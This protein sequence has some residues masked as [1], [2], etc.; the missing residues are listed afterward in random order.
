MTGTPRKVPRA[1]ERCRKQKLKCDV[2][3]PCTLCARANVE[4][5]S[6]HTER[7][8]FHHTPQQQAS[9]EPASK[10]R[11]LRRARDEPSAQSLPQETER[12]QAVRSSPAVGADDATQDTPWNASSTI[13]LVEEAFHHHEAPSPE[14]TETS[15]FLA[16]T[17]ARSKPTRPSQARPSGAP[18][19]LQRILSQH[20]QNGRN[21][22]VSR[23]SGSLL[24]EQ[25]LLSL[26][27]D[28]EPATTLVDNYFGRIHW[29]MLLFHQRDCRRRFQ[30]L[31]G[32][33]SQPD[34]QP[35]R[36]NGRVGYIAV[37]LSVFVTSLHYTNTRQKELL[38]SQGIEPE[39]LKDKILMGLKLR[40]LDI[41]SLGSLEVVQMCILLGS[42]YLYHGE[43]E[44]AWPLCGS[45]LR[46]AQA[47][48]LHR[49]LPDAKSG[50]QSF[51]QTIQDRKRAWWAIYEIETFCSMLYG[52]PLSI[53]DSDCDVA[54]L[55]PYDEYSASISEEQY[56]AKPNLL[57]FKCAMS[58][59]SAIVKSALD[60]LYGTRC[61]RD[62][63]GLDQA[64]RLKSLVNKVASLKSR[65][66]EWNKGLAAKLRFDNSATE[67]D[68]GDHPTCNSSLSGV[69]FEEHLFRLQALSLKLAYENARIL[70]HR[71]LLS[72]KMLRSPTTSQEDTPDPQDPFQMAMHTCR[73]AALE[74]SQV[75]STPCL[76]E[77][78][79][80]YAIAFVSLHLLTAGVTL[81]ISISLDPLSRKSY[82]S[83][84]GIRRLM[85]IQNL[86][87]KKSIVAAQGLDITK[88]LMSLVLAKE[89]DAMF[90]V[91]SGEQATADQPVHS[92]PS[93]PLQPQATQ[94]A[95]EQPVRQPSLQ[96][97]DGSYPLG[98]PEMATETT[99]DGE[100]LDFCE[101]TFMT[102]AVHEYEQAITNPLGT[103]PSDNSMLFDSQQDLFPGN[104]SLGQEQ[105][106]I[107][108]WNFLE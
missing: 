17:W 81:C 38:V 54:S 28:L 13:T 55:D 106:W 71:P 100:F 107:W 51:K 22:Q 35:V 37:L 20:L 41:I 27:P 72:F 66:L 97:L 102:E 95:V 33:V 26:L 1:C 53:S 77:A 4:C 87:K 42:Y 62:Q 32:S 93:E 29:F 105:G 94:S 8:R 99:F 49:R 80:T 61:S 47:L 44:M 92:E 48:N 12:P 9:G 68:T 50:D 91:E 2:E 90:E 104:S 75:G 10:K 25:E 85:Q 64:S 84:M 89:V 23:T 15:A 21:G 88:R 5:T 6:P 65:L 78:S 18:S 7:W 60:D 73:D 43:P 19:P 108:G 67:S 30:D 101:N 45:G 79:E 86:L 40:F 46:I 69:E 74:I 57:F 3:R 98:A 56:A 70:I 34:N 82:E 63:Q 31:Y 36:S 103:N 39:K 52:F 58:K 11:R 83:R 16:S 59:L 76:K 14:E 24:V 96:V